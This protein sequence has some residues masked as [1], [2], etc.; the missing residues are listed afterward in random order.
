MQS[1][2]SRILSFHACIYLTNC[3]YPIVGILC[4][5]LNFSVKE[6]TRKKAAICFYGLPFVLQFVFLPKL[7][8]MIKL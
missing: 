4:L 7:W 2:I 5:S 1:I 3:I 6:T 8:K